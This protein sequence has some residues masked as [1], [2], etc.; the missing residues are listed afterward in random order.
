MIIEEESNEDNKHIFLKVLGQDDSVVKFKFLRNAKLSKL[1]DVYTER[2]GIC[3]D[4]GFLGKL[5][6][7]SFIL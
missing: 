4:D 5:Q 2:A 3:R 1:M 6:W 7:F